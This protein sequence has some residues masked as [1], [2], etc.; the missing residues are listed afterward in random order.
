MAKL[1]SPLSN[2]K[3]ELKFKHLTWFG[4]SNL[5]LTTSY[6]TQCAKQDYY[7]LTIWT[8]YINLSTVLDLGETS[9][10]AAN[11]CRKFVSKESP[12]QT[13]AVIRD[14]EFCTRPVTEA[15]MLPEKVVMSGLK[16]TCLGR[17]PCP[18][19]TIHLLYPQRLSSEMLFIACLKP[20]HCPSYQ[21]A[22][23]ILARH[24]N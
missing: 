23:S 22:F 5:L 17:N 12:V 13:E 6:F 8:M 2:S 9:L 1:L 11:D 10:M 4:S 20:S 21:T 24:Q 7:T 14:R 18:L 19:I 3:Q 16:Q 15:S